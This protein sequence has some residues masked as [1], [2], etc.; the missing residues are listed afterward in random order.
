MTDLADF[1]SK[2]ASAIFIGCPGFERCDC[3]HHYFVGLINTWGLS[4]V[5]VTSSEGSRRLPTLIRIER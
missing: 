5:S 3:L 1:F 4:E 2:A